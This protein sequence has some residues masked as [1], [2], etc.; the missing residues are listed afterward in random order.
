MRAVWEGATGQ[1]HRIVRYKVVVRSDLGAGYIRRVEAWYRPDVNSFV[2]VDER[3]QMRCPIINHA[4]EPEVELV[5]RLE[6]FF[7]HDIALV[8][9]PDDDWDAPPVIDEA[10]RRYEASKE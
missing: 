4:N 1:G 7:P 8:E 6:R 10:V 2:F 3:G 9:Y 5:R